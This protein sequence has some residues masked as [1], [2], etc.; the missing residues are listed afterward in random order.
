MSCIVLWGL[1]AYIHQLREGL[2]VTGMRDQTSWGLYITDFVFFI[3]ISHAGTLISAVLRV[4][5]AGWR[6]PITRLA[7]GITVFALCIGGPMVIIDMGRPDR[8]LNLFTHGRIQSSIFW[9]VL[10]VSTYLTGCIIYLYLPMIPD[11]AFLAKREEFGEKRRKFYRALSL[12]WTGS[13]EEQHLLEK[14]I[15]ILAVI[16]IPLAISVHTVVSWIF[17]MTLRP[18]WNSSI[19]GPYFVV[20]A[21][22]S[23][24]AGVVL[25]MYILRR[26]FHLEDYIEPIHFRNLGLLLLSF[27]LIYLYFNINEYLTT[28]YKVEGPEKTLLHGLFFGDFSTLFWTVQ[29]MVVFVPLLMMM[30]VLGM[31][32]LY[33]FTPPVLALASFLVVVG[34][35]AKRYLIIIPSLSVPYLPNARLPYD[36]LHY[37]PTWVEWSIT[38]AA[39]ALFLLIY[40]LFSKLFPMVSIWETREDDAERQ[41][42]SAVAPAAQPAHQRLGTIPTTSIV[43]I[44]CML[45]GASH[46]RA[47]EPRA[48]KEPQTTTLSIQW[49]AEAASE[50]I[51]QSGGE[52]GGVALLDHFFAWR[53]ADSN[54]R[55]Q[56]PPKIVVTAT[57]LDAKGQPLAYQVVGFKLKTSFGSLDYGSRP[58]NA[59]GKAELRMQDHRFGQYPV[60]SIYAGGAQFAAAHAVT[61]VDFGPRPEVSLPSV[62]VLITPYPTAGI[63]LPFLF[64]YGLMWVMF[65]YVGYLIIWRLRQIRNAQVKPTP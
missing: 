40:M 46:A 27:C 50:P 25:S 32:R 21:I 31:K 1:Y 44:A 61:S 38:A 35:W 60:E 12:G 16:I 42:E 39:V 57:L 14:C 56:N 9:D 63:A 18:G 4:T 24:A 28:G 65:F 49:R 51:T 8:M 58:T 62:G 34:A 48:A 43:L 2:I 19:F 6:R 20:G 45:F 22:Y 37:R 36:W 53:P 7:E 10:G 11:L 26:V 64:F 54:V 41:V 47:A 15:S 30:A 52:T 55:T 23:G 3:G 59:E 33:R 13:V 5:D 29:S 17:A